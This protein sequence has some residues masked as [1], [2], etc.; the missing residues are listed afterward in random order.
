MSFTRLALN[1]VIS[2][3]AS[4][5]VATA[6]LTYV[7]P[8][9]VHIAT[10]DMAASSP[11]SHQPKNIASG[12]AAGTAEELET[13]GKKQHQRPHEDRFADFHPLGSGSLCQAV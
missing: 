1:D 8:S 5:T 2:S 11:A 6:F 9:N 12:E 7:R 4:G 3:T 13:S 10:I